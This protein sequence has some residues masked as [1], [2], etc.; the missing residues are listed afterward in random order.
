[1]STSKP[2]KVMHLELSEGI[3]TLP[4]TPG[5]GGLYVVFWWKGIPLGHQNILAAQLPMPATQLA[6]LALQAI[7]PAVSNHL[8]GE[9]FQAPLRELPKHRQENVLPKFYALVALG[10]PL[11]ML[12]QRLTQRKPE[13]ELVSVVV[14]TRERP[15][16]L[17]RCLRSLQSL[18]R[19]PH[20]ILVVD[21]A[22]TSNA[23]QQVVSQMP[24]IRYV[25]EPRPG[26]GKAR[27]TG[28]RCS[29]GNIIAFTDDDVE[30]HPD[31]LT[32]LQQHFDDPKIMVVTGLV[33]PAELETEAQLIFEKDLGYLNKGYRPKTFDS[34]FFERTKNLG[35]PVW[36]VGAGANMAMRRE[37]FDLVGDFDE[38]LG[39]GA[40]GCSD[41]SEFW[42][43][44]LAE[45][46]NCRYEPTSVVY[47]YHRSDLDDLRRQMY[48]YFR[49]HVAA[50]LFQFA[51]YR[52]WGNLRSL[53]WSLPMYYAGLLIIGLLR[54]FEPRNQTYLAEKISGCLAGI[55]FY[56]QNQDSDKRL[57]KHT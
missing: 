29:T 52:H 10:Q 36:E 2:W 21:N 37:V 23:T 3:S 30:V 45:G 7:A 31:W 25:L 17:A 13:R 33:L 24:G 49:G 8:L 28:I 38:R 14:C 12:E 11:A 44:V 6:N 39:A 35:A 5:Y 19:P 55:K 53:F 40:A 46:W 20:E 27:N 42:C 57:Q 22:P 16:S 56:L 9:C 47:H 26:L 48:Q 43:R 32:R 1:M 18:S 41:D 34:Q 15:E 4:L 54:G 50:L 51:R